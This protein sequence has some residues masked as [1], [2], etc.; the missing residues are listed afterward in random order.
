M[1]HQRG[2]MFALVLLLASCTSVAEV[3]PTPPVPPEPVV[4]VVPVPPKPPEPVKQT[5]PDA[6]LDNLPPKALEAAAE[7][8]K[9]DATNYVA[10]KF[11]KPEN[12]LRLTE[13]TKILNET[14]V[15][16]QDGEVKGRYRPE[17]VRAARKALRNLRAFLIAK[18]D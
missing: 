2:P 14:M 13:L 11:S 12:I 6:I 3:L 7:V 8:A 9:M 5:P 17:D 16:L 18:G 1:R 15:R 4:E 10:W